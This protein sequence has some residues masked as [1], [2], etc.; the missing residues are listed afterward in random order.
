M[1]P[2]ILIA[3]DGSDQSL[4]VVQ[5]ASSMVSSQKNRIELLHI[6]PPVPEAVMDLTSS[7]QAQGFNNQIEN[8]GVRQTGKIKDFMDHA[9]ALFVRAGFTP[10]D[11]V[12]TVQARKRGIARDIIAQ[13]LGGYTAL[14]IGR[15][16]YGGLGDAVMGSVAAKLVEKV[17]NIPIAVIG[18][19]PDT[20]KVLIALDRSRAIRK[21]IE[22]F[23]R[24]ISD[25]VQEITI[26]HIVRP[27]GLEQSTG[28]NLFSTKHEN[29]WLD[30]NTRK[31]VPRIVET[32]KVFSRE[33]F[34]TDRFYTPI[35]KEKTSRADGIMGEVRSM[36]IGTIVAGRRGLTEVEDFS[37]GR[38]TRKLLYMAFAQAFWIF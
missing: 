8:W 7:G 15:N 38:V 14:I 19:R 36:D 32:K 5:Y 1:K 21:G 33:G 29:S 4:N 16:G 3:V 25:A 34:S 24:I 22:V 2:T 13:T 37:M 23:S 6:K 30:E 17:L 26:C 27:L 31:I 10:E 20:S 35:L 9:K 11:V 18:G 12:Q 28:H